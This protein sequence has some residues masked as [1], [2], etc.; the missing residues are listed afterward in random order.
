LTAAVADLRGFLS[1]GDDRFKTGFTEKW[2]GTT[3]AL[4][5][6]KAQAA[7]FTP[8]QAK[9]FA[10]ISADTPEFGTIS[11]KILSL[12]ASDQW[13]VPLAKLKA[14]ALPRVTRLFEL[15]DGHPQADGKNAG[16]ISSNQ[17]ILMHDDTG[18]LTRLST[19]MTWLAWVLLCGG[20]IVGLVIALVTARSIVNPLGI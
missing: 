11:A 7:V 4:A 5:T 12:R 19:F 9:A 13:N 8:T 17:E 10:G 6:L 14:E 20:V 1:T 2:Q 15:I 3:D 16:G 18:N